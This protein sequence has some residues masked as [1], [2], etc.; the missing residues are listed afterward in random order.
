[1]SYINIKAKEQELTL[2]VI[3]LLHKMLISNIRDDIAGRFRNHNEYVRVGKHIAP[4]PEQVERMID[5]NLIEYS[6]NL[7]MYFLEKIVRFHVQFEY[8]HPFVDGNGRI[9][10]VLLNWQLQHLGFP[11]IIIRNKEKRLYYRALSESFHKRLAYLRGDSIIHLAEY[12]RQKGFSAPAV[13]NSA[14]RQNLPAFRERG[15]WKIGV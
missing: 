5:S 14:R 9:G 12:V 1:V 15:V 2:E 3:L 7:D 10:R 8:I 11:P 4:P 6:S 13:F